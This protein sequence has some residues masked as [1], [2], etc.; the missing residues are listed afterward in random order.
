MTKLKLREFLRKGYD[1]LTGMIS[2]NRASF[3]F[4][5]G[6]LATVLVYRIQLT[7]GLFTH[8]VKPFDF[9]PTQHPAWFTL[10]YLPYDLV[11]VLVCFL[12]SWLF[13]RITYLFK[14][15]KAIS[16]SK[17][18]GLILLHLVLMMMLLVHGVHSRLLF[19]VQTGLD[20]SAIKEAFSGIS[21]LKTLKF[22]E[23]RDYLF[24]IFPFAFFWLVLLSPF[25][26]TVWM[27]RFSILLF[28]FLSSLSILTTHGRARDVP[29]EIRLNPAFFLLSDMTESV[30]FGHSVKDQNGNTVKVTRSVS[31]LSRPLGPG[32]SEME[33]FGSAKRTPPWN[34][35]FFIMESVGTRYIFDT[36]H[37]H[38]MPM[39]FLHNIS[40]EGW[41]LKNDR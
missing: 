18:S 34:I 12:L 9:N 21:L 1:G 20:I 40:E 33:R 39:P 29:E 10:A 16:F 22:I 7:I 30:F 3:A 26:L 15:G 32:L 13:S 38:P 8:P 36:S 11:F 24:L 27:V 14:Q 31:P 28:L 2:S 6:L 41:F 23:I 5:V 17:I 4:F 25:R 37:G 35:V 19:D